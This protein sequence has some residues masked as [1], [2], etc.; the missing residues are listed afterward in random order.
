M[1]FEGNQDERE[2][3]WNDPVRLRLKDL[4]RRG[5][6]HT[7][8]R[9]RGHRPEQDLS[10]AVRG[11]G[12][13]RGARIPGQRGVGGAAR[14]RRRG[15]AP[16]DRSEAQAHE[17]QAAPSAHQA[18]RR[19]RGGRSRRSRWR[20]GQGRGRS[21]RGSC[22]RRPGGTGRRTCSATREAPAPENVRILRVRGNS[23]EPEMREGDRIVVDVS[24]RSPSTGETF[25]LW[26]G[27]GLVVK[28]VEAGARPWV[29]RAGAAPAQAD[30]GQ[31]GLRS[32][33][34]PG[35]GRPRGR[36]GVVGSQEGVRHGSGNQERRGSRVEPLHRLPC[37]YIL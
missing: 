18:S 17:A 22:P 24:R 11:P 10:A 34:V 19:A 5:D 2:A 9:V 33:H 21:A 1:T 35:P 14:L 25:V 13:A 6:P 36:Q 28:Q 12:R 8:R 15:P 32:L 26:D 31:P 7:R 16:R 29:G 3:I 4:L 20:P 30:L 27:N 37:N 23:M